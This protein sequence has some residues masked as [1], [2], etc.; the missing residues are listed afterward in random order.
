MNKY[1]KEIFNLGL[2]RRLKFLEFFQYICVI[3]ILTVISSIGI[4][5]I[6]KKI[7]QFI[8]TD[9]QTTAK[10][11]SFSSYSS[12]LAISIFKLI[13]EIF[14]LVI[15]Y[16]Y[17]RKIALTVPSLP[18][19]LYP[20]F[21]PHTTMEYVIHVALLVTLIELQPRMKTRLQHINDLLS[22]F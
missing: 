1:L 14:V 22:R 8:Y 9:D 21:K 4:H 16:F 18:H 13:I 20:R 10:N 19:V 6:Y 3:T 17:I 2:I 5:Y 12:D 7:D 15:T 11:I